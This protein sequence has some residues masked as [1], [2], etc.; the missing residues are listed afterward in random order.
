MINHEPKRDNQVSEP[1]AATG[2]VIGNIMRTVLQA[3]H[4]TSGPHMPPSSARRG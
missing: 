1:M 2:Y 4:E 3:V